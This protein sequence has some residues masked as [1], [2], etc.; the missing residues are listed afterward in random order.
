MAVWQLMVILAFA[1]GADVLSTWITSPDLN[2]EANPIMKR[3]GWKGILIVSAV[4]VI[5]LPLISRDL[6]VGITVTS[7]LV[8]VNNA[9]IAS[10][11]QTYE[12]DERMS[13]SIYSAHVRLPFLK[14][15]LPY[16]VEFLSYIALGSFI[17]FVTGDWYIGV[18]FFVYSSYIFFV[19]TIGLLANW[20]DTL[21]KEKAQES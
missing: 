19:Q 3:A 18:G 12:T 2:L 7:F 1:R 20:G 9:R 10:K 21:K 6:V 17:V 5:G 14:S 4:L 11:K 13:E 8:A 16:L 15:F